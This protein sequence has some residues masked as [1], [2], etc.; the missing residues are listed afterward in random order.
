[1][2]SAKLPTEVTPGPV[3]AP[4]KK[5]VKKTVWRKR[6]IAAKKQEQDKE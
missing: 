6:Q 3:V 2:K 4:K 1:M 5:A